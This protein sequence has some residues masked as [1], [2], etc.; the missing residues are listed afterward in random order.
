MNRL[1]VSRIG[2]PFDTPPLKRSGSNEDSNESKQPRN[3]PDSPDSTKQESSI[4]KIMQEGL[5][6]QAF[7]DEVERIKLAINDYQDPFYLFDQPYDVYLHGITLVSSTVKF[8]EVLGYKNTSKIPTD[9]EVDFDQVVALFLE[10]RSVFPIDFNDDEIESS[11]MSDISASIPIGMPFGGQGGPQPPAFTD[12]FELVSFTDKLFPFY[13]SL[14]NFKNTMLDRTKGVKSK[15]MALLNLLSDNVGL[16]ISIINLILP[17]ELGSGLSDTIGKLNDAAARLEASNMRTKYRA[18]MDFSKAVSEVLKGRM[19]VHGALMI[20]NER[21]AIAT[22]V[23]ESETLDTPADG[24]TTAVETIEDV[25]Q[26]GWDWDI[27]DWES[28]RSQST[29][30]NTSGLPTGRFSNALKQVWRLSYSI[31]PTMRN[32]MVRKEPKTKLAANI[33]FSPGN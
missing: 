9:D 16:I 19:S 28:D 7:K 11:K 18:F 10:M 32:K 24:I 13:D 22:R 1:T 20:T 8:L 5:T 27:L 15:L 3:T 4:P 31:N 14:V 30:T 21:Y 2:M 29:H 12:T 25:F 6:E 33:F 17:T 23:L 26:N